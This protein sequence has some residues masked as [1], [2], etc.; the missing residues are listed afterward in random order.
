MQMKEAMKQGWDFASRLFGYNI[1]SNIGHAY[2]EKVNNAIDTLSDNL[3]SLKSKRTIESISGDVAEVYHVGTFNI[4]AIAAG[5]NS[6]T[7]AATKERQEKWS[8]DIVVKNRKNV[9]T[10]YGSKY[11]KNAKE[12][13]TNQSLLDIETRK[14]GYIGQKRLVASDQLYDVKEISKKRALTNAYKG[15][16]DV[17]DA[18]LDTAQ[19][20]TD[21]ISDGKIHSNKLSKNES[22]EIAQE[23]NTNEIKNA[24]WLEK[25]GI[26]TDSVITRTNIMKKATQAGLSAAV[27]T[28]IMQVTPEIFKSIDYLIKTGKVNLEQIKTTGT[29]AFTSSVEGFLRGSIACALQIYCEKGKLGAAFVNINPNFL[30]T[31]VALTIQTIKNSISVANGTLTAR[32]MGNSLVDTIAIS[33]GYLAGAHIGGIIGQALGF[34][35][36]VIGYLIGSLIGSA[37]S[38]VYNIGKKKLIS[39]CIDSGFAFFGLVEQD[40]SLPEELLKEMGIDLAQISRTEVSRIQIE[41]TSLNSNYEKRASLETVDFIILKRG[42]IGVNKIGYVL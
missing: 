6:R 35:L 8:R 24:K 41:K 26:T 39:L 42:I 34:E 37:F 32:E 10:N 3:A 14:A 36:P 21:T 28:M 40:Y 30:G 22:M 9:E 31:F 38:A 11:Y 27:L 17:A 19:N 4:N 25:H 33:T 12:T 18:Y 15:R 13:A 29:K 20:A 1:S 16:Q 5:S 2:I 23:I 7:E